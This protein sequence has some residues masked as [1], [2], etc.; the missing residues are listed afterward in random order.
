MAEA[1]LN[2]NYIL[3]ANVFHDTTSLEFLVTSSR[4]QIHTNWYKVHAEKESENG[5]IW[6][7]YNLKLTLMCM[8]FK[9]YILA[10]KLGLLCIVNMCY[11][12]W[13]P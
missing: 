11:S 10:W 9:F 13:V 7:R 8:L 5:I 1:G 3:L 6:S 4:Y 12:T 2:R